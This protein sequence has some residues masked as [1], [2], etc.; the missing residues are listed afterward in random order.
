MIRIGQFL[1]LAAALLALEHAG[2]HLGAFGAKQPPL[3]LD[4]LAGWPLAAVL[5]MVGA[6]L[7]GQRQ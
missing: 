5:F 6:I 3:L 7:A 2:A 1:M 4:L